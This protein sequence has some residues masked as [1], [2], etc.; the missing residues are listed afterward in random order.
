MRPPPLSNVS[1]PLV[2]VVKDVRLFVSLMFALVGDD[3]NGTEEYS[4]AESS[5]NPLPTTYVAKP[6]PV[7]FTVEST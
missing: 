6:R 5:R 3:G 4:L 7:P 1:V 2:S